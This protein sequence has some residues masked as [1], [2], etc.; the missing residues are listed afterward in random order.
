[1]AKTNYK[2]SALFLTPTSTLPVVPGTKGNGFI[3]VVEAP[4]I[5]ANVDIDEFKRVTGNLGEN[6]FT[7]DKCS[8]RIEGASFSHKMREQNSLADSLNDKPE[9]GSVLEVGAFKYEVAET[10]VFADVSGISVGDVLTGDVSSASGTVVS[11][12]TVLNT[13]TVGTITGAPFEIT[14]EALNTDAFTSTS[15][16]YSPRFANTNFPAVGSAINYLDGN[17]HTMTDGVIASVA[18]ECPLGKAPMVNFDLSSYIDNNGESVP[19]ANPDISSVLNNNKVLIVG[20]ADIML[21]GGSSIRANNITINANPDIGNFRGFGKQDF[22]I[23]DYK[24]EITATFI[25]ENADY[26]SARAKINAQTVE[27]IKIQLGLDN[28]SAPVNGRTIEILA[29]MAKAKEVTDANDQDSL[30]RTFTWL[31]QGKEAI[32]IKTGYFKA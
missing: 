15:A 19:E 23:T 28:N 30:S 16:G 11:I 3:E 14:G 22:E 21:A 18:I 2:R 7:V 29:S 24:F 25:P 27:T 9:W 1:M 32:S 4:V 26:N 5:S 13:A 31:L 12:D 10:L 6:D 8:A 20:C 17:K